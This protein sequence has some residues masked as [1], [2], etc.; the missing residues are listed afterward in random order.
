MSDT[1]DIAIL[2]SRLDIRV[3]DW[4][5]PNTGF[6][7]LLL[8][9]T[10]EFYT[11]QTAIVTRFR[12]QSLNGIRAGSGSKKTLESRPFRDI[13]QI[14]SVRSRNVANLQPSQ[15]NS[16]WPLCLISIFSPM[17]ALSTSKKCTCKMCTCK[18]RS[19]RTNRV[20]YLLS[21]MSLIMGSQHTCNYKK[22][23]SELLAVFKDL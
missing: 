5:P 17:R 22:L 3:R 16:S 4:Y 12:N 13:W 8:L 11:T 1:L 14:Q 9:L 15:L 18:T 10:C 21:K 6:N 20:P 19:S 2:I 7:P 23:L